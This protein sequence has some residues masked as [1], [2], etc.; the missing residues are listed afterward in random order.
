MGQ[1]RSKVFIDSGGFIALTYKDDVE[2][3]KAVWYYT[4]VKDVAL[5]NTTNFVT[6]R[7]R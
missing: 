7:Q 4:S 6:A 2:H 3:L 5:F 1:V